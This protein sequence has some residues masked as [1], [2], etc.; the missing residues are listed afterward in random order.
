MGDFT[1]E[2]EQKLLESEAE[3]SNTEDTNADELTFEETSGFSDDDEKMM[4]ANIQKAMEM[5][6]IERADV[7]QLKQNMG[8]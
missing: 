2:K 8:N 1:S 5:L 4:C 6:E 3:V 7:R